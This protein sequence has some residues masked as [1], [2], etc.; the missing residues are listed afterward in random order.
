MQTPDSGQIV[1]ALDLR[2]MGAPKDGVLQKSERRL[3]LQFQAFG[4]CLQ[5]DS[6]I[7]LLE[8]NGFEGVLYR[9][10]NDSRGIGVLLISEDPNLFVDKAREV[11][12]QAPFASLTQKLDMTMLGRT[13]ATG[14]EPNLEDWLLQ[15]PRRT[16]LNP[17]W[18]WAIWYPLRR[19]S[20][21][22]L[23]SPQEQGQILF[24]H[25]MIGKSYAQ[26]GYAMDIR[27]SC[28]GLDRNDN[29]FIIG[30]VGSDLFPL[31]HLVQQMR[32]TQQTSRYI[33]S[34]GPFFVG[35][36]YWQSSRKIE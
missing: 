33:Q 7:P 30:L 28:F 34:L 27:L 17:D 23:L 10:V 12:T 18:P 19:K 6:V 5:P 2:E 14:R 8:E 22:A 35:K 29:E 26:S 36:V 13:Y 21:F 16:A 15:K 32:K 1:E 3:Y 4:N 11:L 9:D 20:E 25:G 24:E 31:S